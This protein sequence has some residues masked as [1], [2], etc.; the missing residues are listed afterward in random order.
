MTRRSIFFRN[1]VNPFV[2]LFVERAGSTY[3][4]TTINSHPEIVAVTEKFDALRQMGKG[5]QDQLEWAEKFL[6]PP[7]IGRNQAIG[8]K[9]KLVDVL[10][11]DGFAE[12]LHRY[13]C[14]I[15]QL[16]RRNS[17][18]A[19]VSTINARRQ[20][21]NSGNWNL[22]NE[23]DRLSAFT[24]DLDE[25][26]N[27]LQQREAWDQDVEHYVQRLQL[28][29]LRLFY[30]DLLEDQ[31]VFIQ[32]AFSFLEVKPQPVQGKTLKNTRD[33]LREVVLNFDE[34]RAKYVNTPYEP[35]FDEVL[36]QA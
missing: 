5:A 3:L 14:R 28:P 4:I 29:T 32:R 8:F 33:N 27:L 10:D 31:D 35:M 23:S 11:R 17:I 20:W 30:E 34:L 18:K 2:I 19:V 1:Q 36:V 7:L 6:T 12:L 21:E 15:I 26:S 9:T 25:F 22:L 24:V 13:Q 16:Q